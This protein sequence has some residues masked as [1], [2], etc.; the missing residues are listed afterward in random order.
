M[1]RGLVG[2]IGV[3]DDLGFKKNCNSLEN[4]LTFGSTL[5][6]AEISSDSGLRRRA[7][8]SSES[9]SNTMSS[10]SESL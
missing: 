9:L 3:V 10:P 5:R 8:L 7:R 4:I 1:S 2:S 6:A